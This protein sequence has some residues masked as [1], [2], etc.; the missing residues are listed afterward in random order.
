MEKCTCG[1]GLQTWSWPSGPVAGQ[2]STQIL[3]KMPHYHRYVTFLGRRSLLDRK[4]SSKHDLVGVGLYLRQLGLFCA[5][6][7][8]SKLTRRK[9]ETISKTARRMGI[10]VRRLILTKPQQSFL[11]WNHFF[12]AQ[13]SLFS[14]ISGDL[15]KYFSKLTLQR[16]Q[17]FCCSLLFRFGGPNWFTCLHRPPSSTCST[18]SI[19][20]ASPASSCNRFGWQ[21]LRNWVWAVV[22]G[23]TGRGQRVARQS[24]RKKSRSD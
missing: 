7:T 13:I 23:K 2:R 5:S 9:K 19:A 8:T 20:L 1:S 16:K 10:A 15:K 6:Q 11:I 24:D 17:L 3:R 21:T 12:P 18:S 22:V 4:W 14:I